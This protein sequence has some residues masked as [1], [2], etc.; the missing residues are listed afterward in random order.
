[1]MAEYLSSLNLSN[2][3][4][5]AYDFKTLPRPKGKVLNDIKD[6]FAD[7][8]KRA[9]ALFLLDVSESMVQETG[10][11]KLQRAKDGTY[12]QHKLPKLQLTAAQAD[13]LPGAD[14]PRNHDLQRMPAKMH[15]TVLIHL[16]RLQR[17]Q[18]AALQ[19][20]EH[21][22][23]AVGHLVAGHQAPAVHLLPAG[24]LVVKGVVENFHRR[25]FQPKSAKRC[26]GASGVKSPARFSFMAV[27]D[28]RTWALL[29][30]APCSQPIW[31]RLSSTEW[32]R[33]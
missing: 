25:H 28:S 30:M 10:V 19:L 29:Q 23:Q 4:T 12:S 20:G 15:A 2:A 6:S 22:V 9:R 21:V 5:W 1:M 24:V 13:M 17:P 7:V 16:G 8:R 26:N 33:A 31:R 11:T 18:R 3:A 27:M 32:S 14:P